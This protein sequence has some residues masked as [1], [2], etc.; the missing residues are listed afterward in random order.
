MM[1][2]LVGPNTEEIILED[3]STLNIIS[4]GRSPL[5]HTWIGARANPL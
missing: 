4:T 1:N 5:K 3:V 2:S